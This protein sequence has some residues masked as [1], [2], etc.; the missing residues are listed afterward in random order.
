ME[1]LVP[2]FLEVLKKNKHP[3]VSYYFHLRSHVLPKRQDR[4]DDIYGCVQANGGLQGCTHLAVEWLNE[5]S[6]LPA[7][8]FW[9]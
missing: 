2:T 6:K 5:P 7:E 9:L 3:G 4:F 1:F 8:R